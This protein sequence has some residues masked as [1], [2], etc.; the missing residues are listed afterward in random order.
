MGANHQINPSNNP[1]NDPQ[2]QG[3]HPL[4]VPFNSTLRACPD[5][6]HVVVHIHAY[7][8]DRDQKVTKSHVILP[9]YPMFQESQSHVY[10]FFTY[11]KSQI[12]D[13]FRFANHKNSPAT[14][15]SA[16]GRGSR[17]QRW[18][19]PPGN[20]TWGAMD[21]RRKNGGFSTKVA[22]KYWLKVEKMLWL[23]AS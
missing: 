22:P 17:T 12:L 21:F 8:I 20:W 19:P 4:K 5:P 13:V 23:G 10:P 6:V 3:F 16:V 14:S 18:A 2:I 11:F 9:K 15:A 1:L 7:P